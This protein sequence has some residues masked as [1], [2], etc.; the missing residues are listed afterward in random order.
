[1]QLR[2]ELLL[3]ADITTMFPSVLQ[4]FL[5]TVFFANTFSTTVANEMFTQISANYPLVRSYKQESD[6]YCYDESI[7]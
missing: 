1:M 6:G 2:G 3:T 4:K 5:I 7:Y